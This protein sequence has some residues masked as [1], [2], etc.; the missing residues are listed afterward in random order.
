[1]SD[2]LA[3]LKK[4]SKILIM[5]NAKVL[6]NE[7]SG[8]ANT[9]ERKKVWVLINGIRAPNEIALLAGIKQ[10]AVYQFLK[11]LEN[12]DLI[13]NP[14]GKPPKRLLDFVPAS[15]LGL[16][17]IEEIQNEKVTEDGKK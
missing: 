6:E 15:W 17:K 8:Y 10:T 9:N 11:I 3:E 13:E 7:L 16:V 2:E 4:I 1:M 5:V 14:W 12:A